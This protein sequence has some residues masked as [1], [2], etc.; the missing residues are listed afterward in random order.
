MRMRADRVSREHWVAGASPD[1]LV[2]R[3][4]RSTTKRGVAA[5][6]V[7]HRHCANGAA[8]DRPRIKFTRVQDMVDTARAR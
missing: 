4:R 6:E 2:Y 7:A 8:L 5:R 3:W 1:D